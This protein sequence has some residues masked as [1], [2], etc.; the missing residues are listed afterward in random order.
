MQDLPVASSLCGH[1]SVLEGSLEEQESRQSQ[2]LILEV[3]TA[4]LAIC[5]NPGCVPVSH[6]V[7]VYC[8]SEMGLW[9]S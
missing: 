2:E 1:Y 4:C 9:S 8:Y 7:L 5:Q 3:V 6:L